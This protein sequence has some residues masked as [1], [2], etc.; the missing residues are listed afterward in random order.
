[1]TYSEKLTGK[2]RIE[3]HNDVLIGDG[4]I[5]Y[6]KDLLDNYVFLG[7]EKCGKLVA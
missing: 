3:K 7:G 6:F 5:V 2:W 4:E 1:M